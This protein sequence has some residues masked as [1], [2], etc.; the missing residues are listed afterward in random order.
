[1]I[2]VLMEVSFLILFAYESVYVSSS[3][4]LIVER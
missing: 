2:K 1:M 4:G 3:M